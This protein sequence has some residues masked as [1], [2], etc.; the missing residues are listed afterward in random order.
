M[1]HHVMQA[2]SNMCVCGE[3]VTSSV[4]VPDPA[5][6]IHDCGATWRDT[7]VDGWLWYCHLAVGHDGAHRCNGAA[8]ESDPEQ[9]NIHGNVIDYGPQFGEEP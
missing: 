9:V 5:I 8:W 2:G 6:V 4:H 1:N 3:P 7:E